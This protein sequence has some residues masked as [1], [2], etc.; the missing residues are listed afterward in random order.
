M[1]N[2]IVQERFY[3]EMQYQYGN[4]RTFG[5]LQDRLADIRFDSAFSSED[6]RREYD[7]ESEQITEQMNY[8]PEPKSLLGLIAFEF[9]KFIG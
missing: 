4:G 6:K 2:T 1:T 5:S 9:G 8:I 7:A 3:H